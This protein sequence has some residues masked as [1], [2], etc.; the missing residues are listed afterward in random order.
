MPRLPALASKTLTRRS[1]LKRL[2]SSQ[3]QRRGRLR[4][5]GRNNNMMQKLIELA[6]QQAGDLV[7]M[8][9]D[10]DGESPP[11][12]LA[13]HHHR[14]MEAIGEDLLRESE[15]QARVAAA[16]ASGKVQ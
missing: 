14:L 9:A 7:K 11:A 3:A 6:I 4:Q 8:L 10:E 2:A 15:R 16:A 1:L 13:S 12:I 5:Q